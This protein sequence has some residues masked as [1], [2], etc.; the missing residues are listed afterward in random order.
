M[1]KAICSAVSLILLGAMLI[2]LASCALIPSEDRKLTDEHRTLITETLLEAIARGE[3][4]AEFKDFPAN[5][6]KDYS[7][8]VDVIFAEHPEYF[9]L[10]GSSSATFS[11]V[12]DFPGKLTVTLEVN[13]FCDTPEKIEACKAEFDKKVD[14]YVSQASKL[15][16]DYEK[17]KFVHDKII[18]ETSYD[19]DAFNASK[20]TG[21]YEAAYTAYGCLV[22]GKAVC[23]GYSKAFQYITNKL[24]FNCTYITGTARGPHGWNCITIDGEDYL[25]DVT[26]DDPVSKGES[27]TDSLRYNYFLVTTKQMS[28]EHTPDDPDSVP[29]C[30]ATKYNYYVFEG[31]YIEEYSFEKV[32]EI[33]EFQKDSSMVDIRFETFGEYLLAK[34]DLFSKRKIFSVPAVSGTHISYVTDDKLFIITVNY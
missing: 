18:T 17:V 25:L 8:A 33:A 14:E 15:E 30:S 13:E 6:Y 34:E 11:S 20:K 26:W 21:E 31:Y 29:F 19:I 4:S 16:T 2:C 23:S 5:E 12:L 10:S 3:Y 24:G 27:A 28:I 7:S 1:K 32:C 9:W 22:N